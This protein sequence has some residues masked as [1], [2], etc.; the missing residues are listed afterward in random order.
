MLLSLEMLVHSGLVTPGW[1]RGHPLE[2]GC[3]LGTGHRD[4]HLAPGR[5]PWLLIRQTSG[6]QDPD[7]LSE[8]LWDPQDNHLTSLCFR[9]PVCKLGTVSLSRL[10]GGARCP[11]RL[12]LSPGVEGA[13]VPGVVTLPPPPARAQEEA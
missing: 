6:S 11:A 2:Q 3:V 12:C 1:A 13:L 5:F 8:G 7:L 10:S 9:V 4:W